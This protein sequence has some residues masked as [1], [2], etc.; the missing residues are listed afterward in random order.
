M[1]FLPTAFRALYFFVL[2]PFLV[3]TSYL[4]CG[5]PQ[6]LDGGFDS[7]SIWRLRDRHSS[8]DCGFSSLWPQ[9]ISG[10]VRVV[11]A[12]SSFHYNLGRL[13]D[14]PFRPLQN[15]ERICVYRFLLASS[16]PQR[17]VN[18]SSCKQCKKRIWLPSACTKVCGAY[19][20][21]MH[22]VSTPNIFCVQHTERGESFWAQKKQAIYL[23]SPNWGVNKKAFCGGGCA[24]WASS[25]GKFTN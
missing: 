21:L 8:F 25:C 16:G 2:L 24:V 13:Y 5:V 18:Y 15:L 23:R 9:L 4:D 7:I 14:V 11:G 12:H 3:F 22:A 10:L 19:N 17:I 20:L 6:A 1:S